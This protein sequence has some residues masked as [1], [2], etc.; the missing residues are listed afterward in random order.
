MS[1]FRAVFFF[2]LKK[3]VWGAVFFSNKSSFLGSF[4]ST[5][6]TKMSSFRAVFFTQK[7]SFGG[8]F[9]FK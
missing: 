4:F 7:S 6:R 2:F 5:W 3:A 8:S 9:F 1:S